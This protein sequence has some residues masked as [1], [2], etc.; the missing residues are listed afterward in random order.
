MKIRKKKYYILH[1]L[2]L[3]YLKSAVA[4]ENPNQ[5]KVEADKSIEYFEKKKFMSPQEMLKPLKAI[6]Q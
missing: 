4:Y 5:F 1:F 6:F 2:I 3:I